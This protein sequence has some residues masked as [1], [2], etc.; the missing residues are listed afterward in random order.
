MGTQRQCRSY[1]RYCERQGG[2]SD[3]HVESFADKHAAEMATCLVKGVK[4]VAQEID[5]RLALDFIRDDDVLAAAALERLA[6][7]VSVPSDTVMVTVQMGWVT[8]TG[9]VLWHYQKQAAEQDI[10]RLYGAIGVTNQISIKPCVDVSDISNKITHPL[11]RSWFSYPE[12][13]DVKADLGRITLSGRA[14]TPPT[15]MSP[16]RRLGPHPG[17]PPS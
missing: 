14:H 12:A 9:E 15:A 13:I 6:W 17:S 11:H 1:R 8:L 2:D 4:G 7:D 3:G 5:V 10:R 16:H